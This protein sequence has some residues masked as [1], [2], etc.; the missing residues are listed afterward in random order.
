MKPLARLA[1]LA[2]P[3]LALL[4]TASTA[5]AQQPFWDTHGGTVTLNL[6]GAALQAQGLRA[7][8]GGP[9]AL[10]IKDEQGS[11]MHFGAPQARIEALF[12]ANL[13]TTGE[14]VLQRVGGGQAVR[15]VDLCFVPGLQNNGALHGCVADSL[16]DMVAFEVRAAGDA[17]AT[18]LVNAAALRVSWTGLELR[19]AAGWA[20]A[21]GLPNAA[22]ARVGTLDIEAPMTP[23]GVFYTINGDDC[24]CAIDQGDTAASSA[25]VPMP[26]RVAGAIDQAGDWDAFALDL[27][28]GTR[29]TFRSENL[30]HD[31]D[32][33]IQLRDADG[34]TVLAE[35]DDGGD[36]NLASK[37]EWVATRSGAHYLFVRDYGAGNSGGSYE[38]VVES[39]GA[40]APAPGPAPGPSPSGDDHGDTAAAATRINPNQGL[41]GRMDRDGDQDWFAVDLSAGQT[42]VLRTGD[43]SSDMDTILTVFGPNVQQVAENDDAPNGGYESWVDFTAQQSGTHYLRVTH[44]NQNGRGTYVVYAEGSAPPA[45]PVPPNPNPNPNPNPGAAYTHVVAGSTGPDVIVGDLH[46]LARYGRENGITAFAV[47]TTSCNIGNRNLLWHS[48]TNEHPVIGTNMYR[49]K[50]GRLEQVG[51]SWLKHGFFAL[52]ENLCFNDCQATSGDELGVHCSDPYSAGLN[53]SQSNLGPRSE[54]N[55][56]NG[57]FLYPYGAPANPNQT[58]GL[59]LQ[60]KDADLDPARNQGAIY[61]VEGHYVAAD[62]SRAG[63]GNNNSSARRVRVTGSGTNWNI[64]FMPGEPTRRQKPAIEVWRD[65]DQDV[66]LQGIDI[67]GDGRLDIA[68]KVT[69]N[70]DGT[71]HYEYALYNLSS[72]RSARELAIPVPAGAALTNVGFHDVDYHSGEPF[73]GTDWATQ[74]VGGT[75]SWSTRTFAQDRNA[76]ALRWGTMYNF[77]FDCDRAPEPGQ[78]TIGLFKPGSAPNPTVTVLVPG[79]GAQSDTAAPTFA[80]ATQAIP[81]G[82][83]A[84]DVSW[85]AASDDRSAPDMIS[86]LVWVATSPG[87]QDFSAAP[88]ATVRGQTRAAVTGLA[89]GT[90]YYVVVRARDEAGNLD[91]N[92]VQQGARTDSAD[93]AAPTFAGA[94]AARGMSDTQLEVEWAAAA[95]DVSAPGAIRYRIYLATAAGGQDFTQPTVTTS[96]GALRAT[97]GGLQ[98]DTAYFVVVRAVDEAGREDQNA[99]EVGGRTDAVIGGGGGIFGPAVEV[100]LHRTSAP[101]TQRGQTVAFTLTLRNVT[102]QDQVVTGDLIVQNDAGTRFRV[103]RTNPI[104][105]G[106]NR[107]A[108][109]NLNLPIGNNAAMGRYTLIATF[110]DQGGGLDIA[111]ELFEVGL[112]FIPMNP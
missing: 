102:A 28:A 85:A 12:R 97:L 15:L 64:Q 2:A 106:S 43:I 32:T 27:V 22:G 101:V 90:Q 86:Y 24:G 16:L 80:G 34:T 58:I 110:T 59:R 62:D 112:G 48:Q 93:L 69:R 23:G 88:A 35:D 78:A 50:D 56:A 6:D 52:S 84:I 57:H 75:F 67:Q 46:D 96:A 100:D 45:P 91:Q 14:V 105:I 38:L 13:R 51:M 21:V 1:S 95:D 37:I 70:A 29:Y 71:W 83:D 66:T 77:R 42:Y 47:G 54:V 49:L 111:T 109:Y 94:V 89:Q 10:P 61:F 53:G 82:S 60:V 18:S 63:N 26:G 103:G 98:A 9:V 104:T 55:A 3:A 31:A 36:E 99:V 74:R 76:N 25:R 7:P 17:R 108:V 72:D 92:T 19:V 107:S 41:A 20:Q 68:Y 40:P 33:V 79:G 4:A 30:A 73:D 65:L 44:Y 11:G 39:Q 8:A 87:G 5:G 81:L